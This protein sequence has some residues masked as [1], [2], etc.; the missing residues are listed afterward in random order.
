MQ[1][2]FEKRK[3]KFLCICLS[4]TIQ[5]TVDF[6]LLRK[7]EVNRS[8]SY[9]MDASGKAVNSARVL[10]QLEKGCVRVVCPLG[11][12][13]LATFNNLAANDELPIR[14][15][16]TPG[17]T[18]ECW[19]LLD[20][21]EKGTT[22]LVVSE[23]TDLYDYSEAEEKLLKTIEEELALC[24]AVLLAGSSP[25]YFKSGLVPCIAKMIMQNKKILLAD[26]CGE[27]LTE[28][29]A[30]CVPQII[31]INQQE[32]CSTF[33]YPVFMSD[34]D[35]RSAVIAKSCELKNIVIVTRGKK[36][37]FASDNG[38]F[39]EFPC[40]NV[41]AVNTTACGDSFSAGFLH[42]FM[43]S[44]NLAE[45]LAKGTWCAARNAESVVPGSINN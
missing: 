5:R 26:Y 32:F 34:E 15:V 33:D 29:F 43:K 1:S 13:N 38:E 23:P 39:V 18:R 11:K 28:T 20:E 2:N 35:L 8:D 24:D 21:S 41:K 31:K 19:T 42:E 6:K 30:F 17:R 40:E 9:R 7:N 10:N 25:A 3:T 37:T 22:E 27:N 4:P 36:S 44:K 14:Y 45:S 16:E 12:E